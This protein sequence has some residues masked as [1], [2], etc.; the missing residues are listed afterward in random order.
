LW[1]AALT[2]TQS[3]VQCGMVWLDGLPASP[4]SRFRNPALPP[5]IRV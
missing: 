1:L 5:G 4:D 3:P 2:P